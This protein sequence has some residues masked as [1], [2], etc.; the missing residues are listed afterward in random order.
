LAGE[1]G[2]KTYNMQFTAAEMEVVAAAVRAWRYTLRDVYG[3]YAAGVAERVLNFNRTI[4]ALE[5][6]EAEVKRLGAPS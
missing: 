3:D 6:S 5:N 1:E 2:V 4:Q